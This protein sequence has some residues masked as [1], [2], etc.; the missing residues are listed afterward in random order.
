MEERLRDLVFIVEMN[1]DFRVTFNPRDRVNDD[2]LHD[3]L[4]S[5]K[6]NFVL[7][8]GDTTSEQLV[9]HEQDRRRRRRTA[10]HMQIDLDHVVQRNGMFEQ[11]PGISVGIVLFTSAR[12]M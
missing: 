9:E 5:Q 11:D 7:E 8:V 3:G 10:G 6:R 12:S 4:L 1:G 2:G